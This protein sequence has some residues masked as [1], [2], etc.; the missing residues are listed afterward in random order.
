MSC[1]F[2]KSR[3]GQKHAWLEAET[4]QPAAT[5]Y[6]TTPPAEDS[7]LTPWWLLAQKNQCHYKT[8]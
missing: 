8:C 1:M 6:I 4:V 2:E 5:V 3:A 7:P